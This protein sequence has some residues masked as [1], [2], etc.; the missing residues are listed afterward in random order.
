MIF[1]SF[2]GTLDDTD[3]SGNQVD[4]YFF[5]KAPPNRVR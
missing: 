4:H 1:E 5:D 3:R 2:G